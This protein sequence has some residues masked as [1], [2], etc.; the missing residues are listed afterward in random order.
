MSV[1]PLA[2]TAAPRPCRR[3]LAQT[4]AIVALAGA[5]PLAATAQEDE[6]FLGTIVLTP[7]G[8]DQTIADAP[9]STTVITGEE[10][11]KSNVTDLTDVLAGVQGVVVTG[12]ADDQDIS[13]RG[14]PGQYTLILVDGRR[15]GTRESRPNGSAGVEQSWMPPVAAIERI[16]IVRG[17]QSSLYGS[18]A[19]GGVIN[20]ITKPV[21]DVWSGSTTIETTLPQHSRDG[22]SMQ[23][24]FYL[25]GPVTERLGLQL[26]GRRYYQ[27]ES[28]VYYG[29]G[30]SD[31]VDLTAR[32][33]YAFNPNHEIQVEAGRSRVQNTNLIGNSVDPDYARASNSEV[34]H[35]REHYLMA[36]T[37]TWGLVDADLSFQQEIGKRQTWSGDVGEDLT[38]SSREPEITNSVADAKFTL[39]VTMA[40]EH[41]FVFGGQYLNS[42]L[43][44][45]NSATQS[46]AYQ[47]FSAYQWSVFAE[48]E[49]RIT[50]DF[51]LT[52]G[53]RVN[54]HENY[55]TNI[56]PRLYAVWNATGR[57]T[58]K[59]GVSTGYKAPDLRSTSEGY[60]YA[61]Q[62]G[63]GAIVA[64]PDLEP[65][66]STSYEVSA[67]WSEATWEVS[68]TA[69]H[70]DFKDKIESFNT[71]ES[72]V[73][74][75]ETLNR[76][77]WQNVQDAQVQG[78]EL[79]ANWDVSEAVAMR[80]TYTYTDS[81]QKTGTYAGLP[82]TRTPAHMAS[83]R[84]DW[85][86][87]VPGLEA[88][89]R[90]VYHGEEINAGA[91]IGENGTPYK[92]DADGNVLAYKY[93]AYTMLDIGA[94][95]AI[96][97]SLTLN[98]AIYNLADVRIES[99]DYNTVAEGRRLWL[100][101]TATF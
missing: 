1:R 39:P 80:A 87:P 81:E 79:A 14:L 54:N 95:Y 57:L 5:M 85:Y 8:F 74:D 7:S 46:E 49:W 37:G 100:G 40:G 88:W 86:T 77:E 19:M 35:T 82:L 50:P 2:P 90:L 16:E 22:T 36:Y 33:T 13:I 98:G 32:L 59:G 63:A 89:A 78:F 12:A 18:D 73:V 45:Q 91:R 96:T 64:N 6:T 11:E 92:V 38:K 43:H 93:D 48:D 4:T 51:A 99:A 24:S 21:A 58:V 53:A 56:S 84:A 55:G 72:V 101:L 65:E 97:D 9:G 28:K 68:A 26:W 27:Q 67:I 29:P 44:D 25:T 66:T 17:P 61:T 23:G 31:D 30:E 52:G 15:Q 34:E 62:G 10:L 76:W 69:Y 70:T 42:S 60:Y 83:L 71:G 41:M 75:G 3:R 20:I 94:S 47:T